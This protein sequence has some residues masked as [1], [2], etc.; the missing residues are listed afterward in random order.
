MG[1]M[2]T[3]FL[4]QQFVSCTKWSWEDIVHGLILM[5]AQ[6]EFEVHLYIFHCSWLWGPWKLPKP[7]TPPK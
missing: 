3:T 2:V 1:R 7:Q 4:L 6:L 5:D